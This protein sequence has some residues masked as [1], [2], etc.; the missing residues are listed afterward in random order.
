MVSCLY[1][2]IIKHYV[3]FL[4]LT[5]KRRRFYK[6][7]NPKIVIYFLRVSKQYAE[8][9][10][11]ALIHLCKTGSLPCGF[12]RPS[13]NRGDSGLFCSAV[14]IA[15]SKNFEMVFTTVRYLG[16]VGDFTQCWHRRFICDRALLFDCKVFF[17]LC[18]S[19]MAENDR[20]T[21]F[22]D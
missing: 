1:R 4:I 14:S 8:N 3:K 18:V 17:L 22:V 13:H 19:Y 10:A 5:G 20:K 2:G 15:T 6:L 12:F 16:H 21:Y 11:Q 9:I 7:S